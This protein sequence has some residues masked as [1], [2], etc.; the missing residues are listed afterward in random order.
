M[1][2]VDLLSRVL[3]GIKEGEIGE[4]PELLLALT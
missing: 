1:G 3:V 2:T 4:C